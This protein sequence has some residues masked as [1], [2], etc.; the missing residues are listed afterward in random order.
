[1]T[2]TTDYQMKTMKYANGDTMPAFGLGTWKSK[3]GEVKKAVYT[4]I[5]AGYRHIDC[6][7]IYG[8]QNEVGEGIDQALNEG[9]CRREDLWITS[10]LWNSDHKEAMVEKALKRILRDMRLDYL[11]LFL[12]HWPVALKVGVGMP[13]S[14]DDFLSRRDV[15]LTETWKAMAQCQEKGLTRHIGVS[16]F[17]QEHLREL[18][19]A[20]PKPEMNQVELH[21]YLQQTELLEYCKKHNIFVTAYSPLG[22]SDR[23]E[24]MK[25]DN[26]PL[27]YEN[28]VVKEIANKHDVSAFHI[29]LAWALNRGTAVIPKS[30]TPCHIKSN[31]EA[32]Q[33][34]LDQDDMQKMAKL[35]QEYRFVDGGFWAMEGSPYSIK[36][37]WG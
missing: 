23:P 20:G 29:L 7:D 27:L 25:K 19:Q 17:N 16:N 28:D 3:S 15:P 13:E 35:D 18:M 31:L 22:S 33:I 14:P 8:N 36:D 34:E 9:I 24:Q 4:A 37:I 26:E 1:M 5:A 11:D 21:P 32:T 6:A 2:P 10:K 30:V 12:M